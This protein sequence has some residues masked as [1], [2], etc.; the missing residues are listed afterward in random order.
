MRFRDGDETGMPALPQYAFA[1]VSDGPDMEPE[2]SL[3]SFAGCVTAGRWLVG[4]LNWEARAAW[5]DTIWLREDRFE[6][7]PR[8]R[9]SPGRTAWFNLDGWPGTPYERN[10]ATP[11][12]DPVAFTE[13]VL[14]RP[15]DWLRDDARQDMRRIFGLPA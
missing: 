10:F 4:V 7:R 13:H 14:S 12:L 9:I 8:V 2:I 15:L 11:A 1:L 5:A 6:I 3:T